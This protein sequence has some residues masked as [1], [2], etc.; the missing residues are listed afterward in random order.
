[1]TMSLLYKLMEN[2]RVSLY[3]RCITYS[4]KRK[5]FLRKVKRKDCIRV[6][7]FAANLSMWRYQHLY[8][9]MLR[10]DRFKVYVFLTPFPQYS[11]QE[12]K[13]DIDELKA[14]FDSKQISYFEQNACD[15]EFDINPD[16]LFYPQYYF[17]VLA[18][19]IDAKKFRNRLLCAYPYGFTD[20]Y[21]FWAYNNYFHN[22]AW[23]LFYPTQCNLNDAKRLA[24][25]KGK[26]VVITGYPNADDFL[27]PQINDVWKTQS[28]P[29]KRIV[30]APHFTIEK[31]HSPIFFSTFLTFSKFMQE[32]AKEYSSE[33]QFAF[34]PHPRLQTELYK[35]KAWG[36]ENADEYY[37]WWANQEYTQLE[38]GNFIDLFKS[39]DALIH[40]CG[41]FSIEYFYTKK[42]AMY[43]CRD[44]EE[45]KKTKN[46]V[47]KAA[48]DVHYIG[49][50][51][52]DII[53]FIDN[54]VLKN[55]DPLKERREAFFNKY[56]L[57]PNGKTVA[58]N[59]MDD[60]L[61]SLNIR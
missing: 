9:L 61:K 32:V 56:L 36:K 45:I 47:G 12:Q 31:N 50:T 34:K 53:N 6:V 41:S 26:N 1:M 48:L 49:K 14:F 3:L 60:I 7:F 59:T 22:A 42:P 10:C 25:N 5:L 37:N 54:V 43:L 4:L 17:D 39:S 30:W 44:L 35:H 33:I 15:I 46:E 55:D 21:D 13:K 24:F 52:N 27:A 8:E 20:V 29:K 58:Q 57:P 38:T 28:I 23:K 19:N 11:E 40:D 51:E 2:L 16:I 18:R